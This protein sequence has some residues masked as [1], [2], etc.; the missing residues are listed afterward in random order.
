MTVVLV[1]LIGR[2]KP[3]LLQHLSITCYLTFQCGEVARA[4]AC[5]CVDGIRVVFEGQWR[6]C[7]VA[8]VAVGSCREGWHVRHGFVVVG[9]G[10]EGIEHCAL[11]CKPLVELAFE[12][13]VCCR[14]LKIKGD[15]DGLGK[16]HRHKLAVIGWE[17]GRTTPTKGLLLLLLL[18]KNQSMQ[19][20]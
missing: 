19:G 8:I 2:F 5:V 11:V 14:L 20:N 3:H 7:L 13:L 15:E 1:V 17:L 16:R 4:G 12:K 18:L 9:F 10:F 6:S